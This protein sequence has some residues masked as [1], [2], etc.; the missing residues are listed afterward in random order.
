M[1][2]CK[3]RKFVLRLEAMLIAYIIK[4]EVSSCATRSGLTFRH[5]L[6]NFGVDIYPESN[7]SWAMRS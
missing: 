2:I 6:N 3:Y 4:F 5:E 1:L 7:N